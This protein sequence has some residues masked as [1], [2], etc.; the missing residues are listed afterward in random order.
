MRIVRKNKERRMSSFI[1]KIKIG[2]KNENGYPVS[3]DYFRASCKNVENI[4]RFVQIFGKKPTALKIRIPDVE[5]CL[6]VRYE[7]RKG[8]KLVAISDGEQ[9]W[10]YDKQKGEKVLHEKTFDQVHDSFEKKACNA[11]AEILRLAFILPDTQLMGIWLFE[12]KG[13]KS[14]IKNIENYFD[15]LQKQN[16][17]LNKLTYIL[18]VE[19]VKSQILEKAVFPVVN[20]VA[21]LQENA[22]FIGNDNKNLID[23]EV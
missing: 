22:Q 23:N 9:V 18:T 6:D 14:T 12:T 5:N 2:E 21:D 13:A 11:W 7:L 8:T 4:Q 20:I 16:L 17:P 3:L 1:G 19:K 10:T 15:T